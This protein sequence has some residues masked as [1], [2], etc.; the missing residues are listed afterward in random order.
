MLKKSMNFL[1]NIFFVPLLIIGLL[2]AAANLLNDMIGAS[3]SGILVL[4]I[5]LVSVPVF[6]I[7]YKRQLRIPINKKF[8]CYGLACVI[9]AWQAYLVITVAGF[10]IWDPGNILLKAINKTP[11]TGTSYF[12]SNPNTF[13]LL[14][15][16]HGIWKGLGQPSMRVLTSLFGL[17]SY[18][19]LDASLLT[20]C[21]LGKKYLTQRVGKVALGLGIISLG[22]T[23]WAVIPYSDIPAFALTVFSLGALLA[24]FNSKLIRKRYLYAVLSGLLLGVDYLIKPSLVVTYIAFAII[25]LASVNW[26]KFDKQVLG[27]L[28]VL[29]VIPTI[30]LLGFSAYQQ[31]NSYVRIDQS[32]ALPMMHFA[33]M[34]ATGNG[35]YTYADVKRDEAIKNPDKRN[36]VA[37]KVWKQRVAKMGWAGYQNFL[38]KKQAA[39]ISD[40]T[41]AWGWEAGTGFLKPF[42]NH[43]RSIGQRLFCIDGVA[44]Y[45]SAVK[46]LV[47]LVWLG[48]LLAVL[49]AVSDTSF[50]GLLAKYAFVGFCLFLLLFEGGRSRYAI[51]FLPFILLLAGIGMQELARICRVLR[52]SKSKD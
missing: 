14:L 32:Q 7:A 17:L 13:L 22:V 43:P 19:L 50:V 45:N 31:R 24:F 9:V 41:F 6:L 44:N 3:K 20:L 35:A 40:G 1:V 28:G 36:A 5:L 48:T 2:G 47:R 39:N 15:I 42:R 8:C 16:E 27:A 25:A 49:F 11:W 51:Q 12:S 37:T 23:P 10:S 29:I 38:I 46:I 33:A 26:H 18:G 4:D 34:G 30:M 52:N 21:H